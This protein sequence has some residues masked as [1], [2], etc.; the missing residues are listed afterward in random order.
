MPAVITTNIT[1]IDRLKGAG[2]G[3]P[4]LEVNETF[5][6]ERGPELDWF[7]PVSF[8]FPDSIKDEVLGYC[9]PC[10]DDKKNF[11]EMVTLV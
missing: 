3:G 6:G 4:D 1:Q 11:S 2:S 5:G 7:L 10:N 8:E 9:V